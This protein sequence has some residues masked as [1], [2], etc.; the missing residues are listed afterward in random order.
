M[1]RRIRQSSF[2]VDQALGSIVTF[3]FISSLARSGGA[4]LVG[5]IAVFQTIAFIGISSSRAIG[6]DVWAALGSDPNDQKSVMASSFVLG[7]L[8]FGVN[9]VPVLMMAS[10][11]VSLVLYWLVTPLL[12]VL[13]SLRILLLHAHGTWVSVA[14]QIVLLLGLGTAQTISMTPILILTIYL[15]GTAL[16]V[17]AAL[18]KLRIRP[19]MPSLLLARRNKDKAGPFLF[20][21][22]LGSLTQQLL[23]MLLV[24]FASVEAAGQIRIAQ[25]LLGP[26]SVVHA[27][28]APLLLRQ[29][30]K[31]RNTSPRRI[32][33]TGRKFGFTLAAFSATGAILVA[34]LLS[35]DFGGTSL[36]MLLMGSGDPEIPV[37]IFICGVALSCNGILLG[38]G[39]AAR[40]L[41]A[42]TQLNKWRLFVI[43]PQ[44]GA[45]IL[46]AMAHDTRLVASGLAAAALLA[47]IISL[48]VLAKFA[49]GKH[50]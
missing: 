10:N 8:I 23:F 28:L 19:P 35:A 3:V 43:G 4:E 29:L 5:S 16:A 24:L 12:V 48:I 32:A 18:F 7:I 34:V 33:R 49:R 47:A 44:V 2:V 9:A 42:T 22:S 38:T 31:I 20:E 41:G 17:V 21:I 26:M 27:G 11:E 45:V 1:L 6:A 50:R 40:I 39:T 30:A 36:L 13:D 25:T 37:I 15:A 46:A 14:A